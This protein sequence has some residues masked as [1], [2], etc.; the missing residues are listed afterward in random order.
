MSAEYLPPRPIG[1]ASVIFAPA[2]IAPMVTVVSA[3]PIHQSPLLQPQI[4]HMET[5]QDAAQVADMRTA[6]VMR[7]SLSQSYIRI[8]ILIVWWQYRVGPG[9]V[10]GS[11]I[12]VT[13]PSGTLVQLI[14]PVGVQE[15]SILTYAY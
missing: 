15:G 11:E 10:A 6:E 3:S 9:A 14:L 8:L 7:L 12:T 2:Y 1:A 4:A 5:L 13:T